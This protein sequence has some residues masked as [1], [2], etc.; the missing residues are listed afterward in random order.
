MSSKVQGL[1]EVN[2][3]LDTISVNIK[4]RV[5]QTQFDDLTQSLGMYATKLALVQL[6]DIVDLKS[7]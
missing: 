6:N 4:K 5:P 3:R 2:Q 1:S 7:D